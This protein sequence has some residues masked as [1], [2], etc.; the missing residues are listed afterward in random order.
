MKAINIDDSGSVLIDTQKGFNVWM[1]VFED[2]YGLTS[3]WNK[4]IFHLDNEKDMQIKTFQED[5][6]NFDEATSVAIQFYLNNNN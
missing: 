5:C 3:D 4:Y 6:N 1:D 2:E